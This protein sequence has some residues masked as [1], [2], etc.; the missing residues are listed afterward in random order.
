MAA[1]FSTLRS[2][3]ASIK[4]ALNEGLGEAHSF[5]KMTSKEINELWLLNE[6]GRDE[7][8]TIR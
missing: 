1:L 8:L 2:A 6:T 7:P 3:V 5:L 4:H